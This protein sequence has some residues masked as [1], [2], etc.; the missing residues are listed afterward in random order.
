MT[1]KDLIIHLIND[2]VDQL[3]KYAAAVPEDKLSWKAG[4]DTRSTLDMCQECVQAP[5][6]TID[7][8]ETRSVGGDFS[9]DAWGAIMAERQQ[10]DTVG[11]CEAEARARIAKLVETIQAFPEAEMTDTLFLPFTGKD[12]PYW[13]IMM[14][15]YWNNTWH[16]GQ[17]AFI[18]MLLGDKQMY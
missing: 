8:L 10:W 2:S 17:I 6:W 13:D 5:K 14:Y 12:H 3:F 16:T 18:Q 15:P 11:K 4:A 1:S 9:E 7:M